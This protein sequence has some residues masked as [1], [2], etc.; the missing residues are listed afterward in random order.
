MDVLN[1]HELSL[2]THGESQMPFIR[3][4]RGALA[5]P[6]RQ[7]GGRKPVRR[8]WSEGRLVPRSEKRHGRIRGLDSGANELDEFGEVLIAQDTQIE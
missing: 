7:G 3:V 8:T 5:P 4:E 2:V 1:T 6:P